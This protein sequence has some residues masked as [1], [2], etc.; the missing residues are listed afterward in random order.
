MDCIEKMVERRV[1]FTEHLITS[2]KSLSLHTQSP[3]LCSNSVPVGPPPASLPSLPTSWLAQRPVDEVGGRL[4]VDAHVE[5]RRV[6]GLDTQVADAQPLVGFGRPSPPAVRGIED[7]RDAQ[8]TQL[9]VVVG[10]FPALR[11]RGWRG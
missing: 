2:S 8:A 7:V 11:S 1:S 9:T 4:E 5:G 6:V 3:G 10:D